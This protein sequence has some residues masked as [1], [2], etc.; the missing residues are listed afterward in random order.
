MKRNID[1]RTDLSF[2]S[3]QI[4]PS[5]PASCTWDCDIDLTM[6][7][8]GY[9]TAPPRFQGLSLSHYWAWL[10]YRVAL[11]STGN[12]LRLRRIW[13]EIDSHQKT[14]LSDDF[15][16]GFPCH[17]LIDQHGFEDFAD[18]KF[19]IR[20]LL[21]GVVAVLGS[22]LRGPSKSPDFIAVD[23]A[24]RLHILECK[25]SQSSRKSLQAAIA[26]GIPQKNNLSNGTLFTSCMVGGIF[27]PQY[28]SNE[29]AEIVF[30]DPEVDDL[31]AKLGDLGPEKVGAGVRRISLAKTLSMLGLWKA[32]SA[33]VEG[34]VQRQD[35]SFV[36]DL[37]K[38]ELA[39]AGFA[40]DDKNGSWKRT[41]DFRSLDIHPRLP[42]RS[43]SVTTTLTLEVPL[44]LVQL[45]AKAVRQDGRVN[46]GEIDQW[47][48][49]QLSQNR[50]RRA[51][52]DEPSQQPTTGSERT[53]GAERVL[54]SAWS[55]IDSGGQIFDESQFRGWRI[56]SGVQMS[57][58]RIEA[59]TT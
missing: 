39:F 41:I 3:D 34:R 51:V 40:K 5:L 26:R 22:D 56:S 54:E 42:I 10:R 53:V 36:R 14:V 52:K 19:L 11:Q 27:V 44:S 12:D 2:G 9:L 1:V 20:H 4:L 21:G 37:A 46:Q 58:A 16:M 15:G 31:L 24:G 45:F 50:V 49:T 48:S 18:T 32:A 6:L 55:R 57:V 13:G 43:V 59:P 7:A 33:V 25:G 23:N 35:V 29:R 28:K 30:A 17:Y 38:G 47:I 8:I